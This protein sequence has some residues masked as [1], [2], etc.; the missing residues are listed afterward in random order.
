MQTCRHANY[1][2]MGAKYIHRVQSALSVLSSNVRVVNDGL[3]FIFF[4]F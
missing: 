3:G 2:V 4:N 1:S